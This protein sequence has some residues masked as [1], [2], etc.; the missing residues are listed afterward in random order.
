MNERCAG[1][2]EA[3][4]WFECLLDNVGDLAKIRRQVE[5]ARQDLMRGVAVNFRDRLRSPHST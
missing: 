3:L 1:A 4:A 5:D 2:I